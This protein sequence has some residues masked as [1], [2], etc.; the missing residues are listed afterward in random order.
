MFVLACSQ[1]SLRACVQGMLY[2]VVALD[3][4]LKLGIW[5][6][7]GSRLVKSRLGSRDKTV[8]PTVDPS[9]LLGPP[10]CSLLW[11]VSQVDTL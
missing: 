3:I 5:L 11:S 9:E 10:G 4:V 8:G 6:E 7:V 2:G 1:I